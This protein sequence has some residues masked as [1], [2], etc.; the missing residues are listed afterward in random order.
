MF[1]SSYKG[2]YH[3]DYETPSIS[4]GVNGQVESMSTCFRKENDRIID[5]QNRT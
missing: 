4:D 3:D 1:V 5:G 2:Q